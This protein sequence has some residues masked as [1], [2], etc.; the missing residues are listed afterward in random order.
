MNASSLFLPLVPLGEAL[1]RV[2][3]RRTEVPGGIDAMLE[4]IRREGDTAVC[5]WSASLDGRP[6]PAFEMPRADLERAVAALD[7]ALRTQ[8]D[9]M[10]AR[11]RAFAAFQREAFRGGETVVGGA[12]LGWRAVPVRC[13]AVYAPGGRYPLP[14]SVV[15]GVV[16]ARAAGVEE[17]VVLS[18]RIHP[19][20][21]AAAALA[22]A[23]RVFDLGG[24]HGVAAAAWG[25]CG[26]P[27]ADLVVGPGNRYVT[28]AKKRL[29]GDVGIEFP[30]GPSELLV[31]ASEGAD[32][33]WVAADLLAQAEHDPD[34]LPALAAMEPGLA[35]AVNREIARLAE[36]LPADSPLWES[37]PRGIAVET[38]A[39]GAVRLAEA[40]APEH[41][42]L[43]GAAAEAMAPRF[44]RYGA[45]FVGARSAEVFGDY[46]AGPN[47]VLPTC[48]AARFAGGLWVGSFLAV[49]TW[50]DVT[51]EGLG[52]L[53][54]QA[55]TLARAEGL[56]AHALSAEL[57]RPE[58][59]ESLT[60][61]A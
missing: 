30:A 7:P 43:A 19:V 57:R 9:A 2:G 38:D 15:M 50:L 17:V 58:A 14:S 39:D 31:V 8:L 61:Q 36:R 13:A 33:A 21:A 26:L 4:E 25:L 53:V 27:R 29:Y 49:R 20:T 40:M 35:A 5:R 6:G 23:D 10:I 32:P 28:A 22:G 54:D 1:A 55:S 42:S 24:A 41:L 52:A 45:L 18:P 16:P 37:I 47:H 12:R 11:V 56:P 44:T 51:P 46:G 34:A 59:V 60:G 3:A 48:G